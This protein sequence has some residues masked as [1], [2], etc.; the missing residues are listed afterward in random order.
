MGNIINGNSD[1][2]VEINIR[3]YSGAKIETRRFPAKDETSLKKI[4]KWIREKYGTGTPEKSDWL[5][6]DNQF[7]KF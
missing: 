7:F 5:D 2:I 6:L 4:F 3:D 1:D